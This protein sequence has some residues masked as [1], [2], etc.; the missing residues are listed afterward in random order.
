MDGIGSRTL[1]LSAAT[2]ARLSTSTTGGS[3]LHLPSSSSNQQQ[4]TLHSFCLR[5]TIT[6]L[7][8]GQGANS[9][10]KF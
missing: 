10:G 6:L 9:P 5:I 8:R 3:A 1:P 4:L 7:L 2:S